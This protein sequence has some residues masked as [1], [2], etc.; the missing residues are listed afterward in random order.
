MISL[1]VMSLQIPGRS[2]DARISKLVSALYSVRGLHVSRHHIVLSSEKESYDGATNV[3]KGQQKGQ[4][5]KKLEFTDR[6]RIR[7]CNLDLSQY[8]SLLLV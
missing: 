8:M 7:T 2:S 4:A 1:G 6:R 5:T 3:V